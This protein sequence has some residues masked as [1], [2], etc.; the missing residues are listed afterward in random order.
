M[1]SKSMR[2]E[3]DHKMY[4]TSH[5]VTGLL[6]INCNFIHALTAKRGSNPEAFLSRIQS[7]GY[8]F[9]PL[10][11]AIPSLLERLG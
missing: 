11:P 2:S 9:S 3:E 1:V 6:K 7:S 5:F 10:D 8:Y 4:L